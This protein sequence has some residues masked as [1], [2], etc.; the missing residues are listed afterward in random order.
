MDFLI[1]GIMR[2]IEFAH[3]VSI[4]KVNDV[5]L[6]RAHSE[7]PR[8]FGGIHQVREDKRAAGAEVEVPARLLKCAVH[9]EIISNGE[10]AS[11]AGEFQERIAIISLGRKSL[12]VERCVKGSVSSQKIYVS[13]IVRCEACARHP[14]S[15]FAT[16]WRDV[17]DARLL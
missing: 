3:R 1:D 9:V 16:V 17:K 10:S 14:D 13:D 5:V 2:R 7:M 6:S 15:A 8:L 11:G 12:R 4:H